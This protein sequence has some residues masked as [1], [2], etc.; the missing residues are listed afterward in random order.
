MCAPEEENGDK[1]EAMASSSTKGGGAWPEETTKSSSSS[2][3]W[4]LFDGV[5]LIYKR[6]TYSYMNTVL[7]KGNRQTLHDGTHLEQED[8]F[9]V[10]PSME[11]KLLA[12]RFL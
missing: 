9:G 11:S 6:W 7:A 3:F 5:V 8:L 4:S 12:D 2:S 1:S 10:P